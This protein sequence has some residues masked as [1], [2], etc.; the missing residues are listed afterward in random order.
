MSKKLSII[1]PAYNA[2]KYVERCI[3]SIVSQGYD[4]VEI[5]LV[6]DGSTDNTLQICDALATK[7]PCIKVLHKE[8][9]GVS[10]ARNLGIDNAQGEYLMFVDVDDYLLPGALPNAMAV[11]EANPDAD[12]SVFSFKRVSRKG[13]SN[14]T[15]LP[16]RTYY[17]ADR[18]DYIKNVDTVVFG[19]SW[20]KLYNRDFI[21]DHQLRF[22]TDMISS[23]DN[24]FNFK[25][26]EV[27]RCFLTSEIAVYCYDVNYQSATAKFIGYKY[28]ANARTYINIISHAI[29]TIVEQNGNSLT[30]KQLAAEVTT[31]T[32]EIICFNTIFQIY[33]IYRQR[34]CC[35]VKGKYAWLKRLM[36][37]MPEIT[38]DWHRSFRSGFPRIVVQAYRL[39]PRCADLLLRSVFLIKK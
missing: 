15:I 14:E 7:Y 12:F 23:E 28:L 4:D 25:V 26:I 1:I 33:N 9:G 36:G 21:N 18:L 39:H 29:S 24:C 8:N 30:Q 3:E 37:F 31:S 20:A 34:G 22:D 35:K 5:L 32:N 16:N 38:P 13:D 27:V 2:A 19:A 10:S 17:R 6:D 11:A